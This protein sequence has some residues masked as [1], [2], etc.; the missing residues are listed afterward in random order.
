MAVENFLLENCIDIVYQHFPKI[1]SRPIT[2]IQQEFYKCGKE[3]SY[4]WV[5]SDL[6]CPDFQR[7]FEKLG[8]AE[9]KQIPVILLNT[10]KDRIV[11]DKRAKVLESSADLLNEY[12]D[13]I[14]TIGGMIVSGDFAEEMT[15]CS[16]SIKN[17][18]WQFSSVAEMFA[19]KRVSIFVCPEF[20]FRYNYRPSYY[21][22]S[23]LKIN[24]VKHW[25][26]DWYR[27]VISL[28]AE[29][30]TARSEL[31]N[32]DERPYN[33]F[34]LL[35]LMHWRADGT[36][37][38]HIFNQIKKFVPYVTN[39]GTKKMHFVALLPSCFCRWGIKHRNSKMM[40]ILIEIYRICFTE[41]EM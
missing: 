41:N 39:K 16:A 2:K 24:V 31:L 15:K 20:L 37:D 28:P 30:K 7:V 10:F 17:A 11:L 13:D 34:Y 19:G 12:K 5:C 21:C 14:L 3:F 6:V 4:L 26:N 8:Q 25:A 27:A 23:D 33:P 29:Y 18:F 32:I 22:A 1:D 9:E 40:R 35:N 38:K 36:Y